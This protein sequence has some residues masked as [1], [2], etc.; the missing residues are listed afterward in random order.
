MLAAEDDRFFEH[1][2]IDWQGFARAAWQV[3]LTGEPRQGGSTITMQ[4]A[5]NFFLSFEKTIARKV[6]EIFLAV[7]IER[8][9]TKNEIL[10]LYLN[11]IFLGQRA[12]GVG[13]A[14]EVYFG[15]SVSE[16]SVSEGDTV[17]AGTALFTV[18][19][20]AATD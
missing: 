6:R 5:R 2:G 1:P 11:K 19:P 20:P 16:L 17:E 3:A 10:T 7:R 14:A 15:K 9:L 18:D 13:A 8:A 4:V 12:Y